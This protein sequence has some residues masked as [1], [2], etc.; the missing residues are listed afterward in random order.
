MLEDRFAQHDKEVVD[1]FIDPNASILMTTRDYVVRPSADTASGP[2]YVILP[3]VADAKGR[4]YSILA[5]NADA[6]NTITIT[7]RD[8]SECWINDIVF[9]GKCDRVLMYSDGL[10][11]IPCS[12]ISN[13]PGTAT[14]APAGTTAPPVTTA[15]PATGQV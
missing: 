6:V 9:N 3:P 13:W 11:W 4:F 12:G 8:D 7:D 1:K 15:A 2:I 14:T 5:R 10:A